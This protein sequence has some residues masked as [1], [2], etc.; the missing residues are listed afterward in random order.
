MEMTSRLWRAGR[1]LHFCRKRRFVGCGHGQVVMN[2]QMA[3]FM[4]PGLA[5][6]NCCPPDLIKSGRSAINALRLVFCLLLLA[7]W[8][9]CPSRAIAQV[10][11][12]ITMAPT[13]QALPLGGT[14]SLAVTAA[15]DAPLAYQWFKDSRLLL[16]QTNN[17]LTATNA[18]VTASGT[19]YVVVTNLSGMVISLPVAVAVGNPSLLAYGQNSDGQL[20]NGNYNNP[21]NSPL[22]V[23]NNVIAGSAGGNHSLF[24]EMDG[25]L[26]GMG[27][28]TSG[29]LGSSGPISNTNNPFI[30]ATNVMAAAAGYAHSL[31]LTTAGTL[32]T[33]GD[34]SYGELGNGGT[35]SAPG[36][37]ASNVV[38]M[39]AGQYHSLF[40]E[41]DG[42]L[43]AMGQNN[44]GQLGNGTTSSTNLPINIASNVVAVAAGQSHSLFIKTDGTLWAM[45]HNNDGQL[46]NGKAADSHVPI[47]VASNVEAVAAGQYH[48]LFITNG[49]ALWAM[50]ADGDG[51]LGNGGSIFATATPVS[52]ASNVVAVAGG[53]NYSVFAKNDGTLWEM[54]NVSGTI[55]FTIIPPSLVPN[56][57][58]ANVCAADQASHSLTLGTL[59]LPA[60][61]T[62]SNLTQTYTGSGISPTASTTP[63]G[64][65]VNFTYNGSAAAPTNVGFYTVIGTINDP[66]YY[67][68]VTNTLVIT[69]LISGPINQAV[70]LG[71]TVTL[72]APVVAGVPLTLQ[73]FKDNHFVVGATNSTLTITNASAIDSGLYYVVVSNGNGLDINPPASV[74][75]GNPLL[76][77]WGFNNSGQLG[78]G[79]TNNS[80][81]P[82]SVAGAVVTG[83]AGGRHSLFVTTNGTLWAMGQ[84]NYGQFGNGTENNSLTAVNVAS[85]VMTATA[86]FWYSLFLTTDGTLWAMG[87]PQYG[88]LCNGINLSVPAYSVLTPVN[89]ASGV[90]EVATGDEHS[91]FVRRDGTLWGAGFSYFGQLGTNQYAIS[92]PRLI[93][94]NVVVATG[95]D[96]HSLFITIDGT[97]WGLGYNGFGQ[98]GNGTTNNAYTPIVVASNVLAVAAGNEHSLFVTSDGTLWTM[99]NNWYGQLGN[100]T[101]NNVSVP[102]SAASNVVAVAAGIFDSLFVKADGTLWTMG[103]NA[104]GQLGDGTTNDSSTPILLP[105]LSIANI[106]AGSTGGQSL[107]VGTMQASATVALGN[108]NQ[109]YT[110]SAINVTASTM[111]PGLKVNLTYNGSP[112]APTNAGSYTVIGTISDPNYYGSATNTLVI[113]LPPQSFTASNTSGVNGTQLTLQLS[114]TPT[115]PYILQT[116]TNLTPPVNWQSMFT[117]PADANGNW[118]LTVSNLVALPGGFYRAVGQ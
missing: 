33:M 70:A 97:L 88:E 93:A 65:T 116:A 118:D 100:G 50:G 99:G 25:T 81:I 45:G 114:G 86:G 115:Y 106:F 55:P 105:H 41:T 74:T 20:G 43:W 10:P 78:I 63:P 57:I 89:V 60:N 6:V 26:W 76:M 101:T 1:E 112:L 22:I 49:G 59:Q 72:S 23:A 67:G 42:T 69:W 90:A 83:A 28:N 39:A 61:V 117:N 30:V 110:G 14:V 13:N 2:N 98:L 104:V 53:L 35:G 108:L 51:Q 18:S 102:V 21:V 96:W 8:L 103:D 58:A 54:G 95:G 109:L 71:G 5:N 66:N 79:S 75:V 68:S 111:P 94:T 3:I 64:L 15:G 32:W 113:G 80:T 44:Y 11:P 52:V 37:V 17:T 84:N 107:A 7:G 19:Y 16:Y 24:V 82:V 4:F 56:V 47:V 87:D 31:F 48:S 9:S 85:N 62:L 36:A 12:T 40:V 34:N 77:S 27:L 29:Q 46:G 92:T 91:L 73:W 38:A